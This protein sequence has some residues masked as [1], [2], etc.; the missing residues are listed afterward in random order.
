MA[1]T[2]YPVKGPTVRGFC[3]VRALIYGNGHPVKWVFQAKSATG[4]GSYLGFGPGKLWWHFRE[5]AVQHAHGLEFLEYVVPSVLSGKPLRAC[6]RTAHAT[7]IGTHATLYI[8]SRAVLVLVA[9]TAPS[10]THTYL[11]A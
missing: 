8:P 10:A 11:A 6:T 3:H 5:Q 1:N 2:W 4:V 9:A 7:C